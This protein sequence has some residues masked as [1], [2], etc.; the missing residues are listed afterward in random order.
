ME[1]L[2]WMFELRDRVSGPARSATRSLRETREA[3][4]E[5]NA[6]GAALGGGSFG[7]SF[8][9]DARRMTSQTR[10]ATSAMGG[11]HVGALAAVTAV[12]ALGS[13]LRSALS[14]VG[15][16]AAGVAD[17][18]S[19]FTQAVAEA[20]MFTGR[21]EFSLT[22]ITGSRDR[23]SQIISEARE[24]ADVL[25][26]PLQETMSS[27]TDLMVRGFNQ[28]EATTIFQGL[29][30]L[31]TLSPEPVDV[32]RIVLAIGQIR[33]AGHLQGDE[34]R[35]LQESGLPLDAV[36]EAMARRL[37]VE[38]D[39]L[40]DLQR[41]GRIDSDTAIA[42]ILEGI[43]SRG[44]GGP[45]GSLR[46]EFSQT[47]PGLIER[48]RD[49]PTRLFDA[50]ASRG[51]SSFGGLRDMV[52][53]IVELLDPSSELFQNAVDILS[54][55][56]EV[57]VELLRTAW[58]I[59]RAF[60]EGL[61]GAAAE[62][63]PI[64][65][66]REGLI[67]LREGLVELRSS[68]TLDTVRE[69]AAGMLEFGRAIWPAL[70]G[71]GMLA[72]AVGVFLAVA[73]AIPTATALLAGAVADMG[74]RVLGHVIALERA[75]RE[76]L[77]GLAGRAVTWGRDI[78]AGLIG[79]IREGLARVRDTAGEIGQTVRGAVESV[80]GIESPSRVMQELGAMTGAGFQIGLDES[81]PDVNGSLAVAAPALGGAA[82]RVINVGGVHIEMH[83]ASGDPQ[84]I[85]DTVRRILLPELEA[86]FEGLALEG[87][88][89]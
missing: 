75:F 55:G 66:L 15:D 9:P 88:L 52:A 62:A 81:M 84:S 56:F 54:L 40:A 43:Q 38:T 89:A 26:T 47:L 25:G 10:S 78:V 37:G 32:S 69:T 28:R 29:S 21:L 60:F 11:F 86:A 45:L 31:Q 79:G 59:G 2:R 51:S 50:I 73:L 17:I 71:L 19:R 16:I 65:S 8:F 23:A 34:L 18:V 13:V 83:I 27:I 6:A 72:V 57:I 87:G 42:S 80:L 76:T 1:T 22:R 24:L 5:L 44:G 20:G 39:A 67:E 64:T 41:A 33:N 3:M 82:S 63:D 36:R 4:T 68:G 35:Q 85:E 61:F 49:A 77:G 46:Q 58:E 30:D 70:R 12:V 7:G 14:V 48:L 74:V 53:S